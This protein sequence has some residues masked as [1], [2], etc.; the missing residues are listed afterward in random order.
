MASPNVPPP[1]MPPPRPHRSIAGPV[2]LILMGVVFLLGTM[3]ILEIHHIGWLFARF[4][5]SLIHI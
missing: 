3:G 4:W 1:I 2:I 5:L